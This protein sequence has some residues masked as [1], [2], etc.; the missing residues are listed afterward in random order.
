MLKLA[1]LFWQL[2][3]FSVTST[4]QLQKIHERMT[5]DERQQVFGTIGNDVPDY[6]IVQIHWPRVEK[7]SA[8]YGRRM[9]L[10]AFGKNIELWLTP[11]DRVLFSSDTPIYTLKSGLAGPL[12]TKDIW[13]MDEV[14]RYEDLAKSAVIIISQRNETP[15]VIGHIASE[16]LVIEPIPQRLI[17]E[18]NRHRRFIENRE[19]FADNDYHIV[20]KTATPEVNMTSIISVTKEVNVV[21]SS[22]AELPDRAHIKQCTIAHRNCIN[23]CGNLSLINEEPLCNQCQSHARTYFHQC[24]LRGATVYPRI[25]VVVAHDFY[26]RF[27]QDDVSSLAYLLAF[28]NG[29]D[30]KYRFFKNPKFRLNIAGIVLTKDATALTYI[31]DNTIKKRIPNLRGTLEDCGKYWY[32]RKDDIAFDDYDVIITMT[33]HRLCKSTEDRLCSYGLGAE[34]GVSNRACARSDEE[35][36]LLNTAILRERAGLGGITKAAHTLARLLGADADADPID[37]YL[38]HSRLTNPYVDDNNYQGSSCN[39]S[40][41]QDFL[42]MNPTCLNHNPRPEDVLPVYLPGKFFDVHQQCYKLVSSSACHVDDSICEQMRC[43]NPANGWKCE[44]TKLAAADGTSCGGRNICLRGQ[45][46]PDPTV[47]QSTS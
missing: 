38:R 27:N 19:F 43:F 8:D 26:K 33:S 28:W 1:F 12:L 4:H 37:C 5:S 18:A 13:V 29:V 32:A 23:Q 6:E 35:N 22:V 31:K 3:A 34:I 25:L 14:Q 7:R 44:G 47:P 30:L 15:I 16:N 39:L 21:N 10:R 46:V 20:H 45:C 40:A 2:V 9:H 24:P 17:K 11:A 41:I 42:D 36:Q